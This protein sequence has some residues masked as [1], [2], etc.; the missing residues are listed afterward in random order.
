MFVEWFK[1]G[2]TNICYNALDRHVEA[3]RGDVPCL[4]WEGNDIGQDV[5]WSYSQVGASVMSACRLAGHPDLLPRAASC[6]ALTFWPIPVILC[7]INS[8]NDHLPV[9]LCRFWT[10]FAA[11]PTG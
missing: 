8:K 6:R 7:P 1:G 2:V 9:L 10:R 11:L 4:L 5:S 3:G